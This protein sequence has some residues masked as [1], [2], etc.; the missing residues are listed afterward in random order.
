M[1]QDVPQ[2]TTATRSPGAGSSP[3]T[4]PATAAARRQQ[5]GCEAIS[6]SV[7]TP[8]AC[9]CATEASL[10]ITESISSCMCAFP[11]S[12]CCRGSRSGEPGR[13]DRPDEVPLGNEEDDQHGDQAHHVARHQQGPVG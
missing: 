2:P 6:C 1:N 13:G 8:V 12:S 10:P 7:R 4:S 5:S 9:C 3:A 11:C